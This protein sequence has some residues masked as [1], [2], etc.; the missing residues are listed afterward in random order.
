MIEL[1]INNQEVV[2]SDDFSINTVEEN[3]ILTKNG[4]FTLDVE[5]P[6]LNQQNAVTFSHINRFNVSKNKTIDSAILRDDNRTILHGKAIVL[7]I[8]EVAVKLQLVSGNSELNY[9]CNDKVLLSDIDFGTVNIGVQSMFDVAKAVQNSHWPYQNFTCARNYI[10]GKLY[11]S[12]YGTYDSYSGHIAWHENAGIAYNIQPYFMYYFNR[13]LESLGFTVIENVLENDELFKRLIIFAGSTTLNYNDYLPNWTVRKFLEE[14]EKFANVS[15]FV[16]KLTKNV[17]VVRTT[18]HYNLSGTINIPNSDVLDAYEAASDNNT[19]SQLNYQ[20]TKFNLGSSDYFKYQCLS[21][22]VLKTAIVENYSNFANLKNAYPTSADRQAAYGTLKIFYIVSTGNYYIVRLYPTNYYWFSRV[23]IFKEI[24]TNPE[25]DTFTELNIVPVEMKD[26]YIAA[27]NTVNVNDT[28]VSD[29]NSMILNG[30][31]KTS[32]GDLLQVGI[33]LGLQETETLNQS[34]YNRIQ[35]TN[36]DNWELLV[37]NSVEK[38]FSNPTINYSLSLL[39]SYGLFN[40]YYSNHINI[41]STIKWT[42]VFRWKPDYDVTQYFL[43]NGKKF[44]CEKIEK[45]RINNKSSEFVTGYFFE[46]TQ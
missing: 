14:V 15:F 29:I 8:N 44:I 5:L 21:S 10:A 39:G 22:E 43:F 36:T 12:I 11:N 17:K 6:L 41:D 7:S 20:N 27:L 32:R 42:I 24:N 34:S 18:D 19:Y 33:Q 28:P 23:N 40:R 3:A 30:E 26:V 45:T 35:I 38:Q 37:N 2:L 25:V 13:I 9:L 31:K 46:I 1:Y 16:D 4:E